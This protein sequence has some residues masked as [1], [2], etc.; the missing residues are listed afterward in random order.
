[1]KPSNSGVAEMPIAFAPPSIAVLRIKIPMAVTTS[2]V[3]PHTA[4]RGMSR[5]G[6]CDSSA[7]SGSSSIAR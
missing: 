4:A 5:L 3:R 6:S 1:L 2:V 7:A